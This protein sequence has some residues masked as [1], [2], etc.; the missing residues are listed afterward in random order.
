MIRQR[1]YEA[2]LAETAE[3]SRRRIAQLPAAQRAMI[4]VFGTIGMVAH[5]VVIPLL[6]VWGLRNFLYG[7]VQGALQGFVLLVLLGFSLFRLRYT[8][9]SR[10]AYQYSWLTGL[11]RRAN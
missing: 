4:G 8:L 6:L 7:T 1:R 2:S 5:L 11:P 3:Q 10:R 9:S